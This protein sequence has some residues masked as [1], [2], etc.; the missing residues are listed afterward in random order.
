MNALVPAFIAALLAQAGDRP[1]WLAAILRDRRG[2]PVAILAAIL[3]VQLAGAVIAIAGA[4]VVAPLLVPEARNL[5]L[6][7]ALSFAG[8]GALWPIRPPDRLTGWRIGAFPTAALGLFILTLGDRT[9]FL[10][11][12]IGIASGHPAFAGIGAVAGAF[13][14]NLPAV[15]LGE[16]AWLAL[17][18]DWLRRVSGLLF[19][20]VA[21]P[22][23]LAALRLI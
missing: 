21:V 16:A 12:T 13:L 7:L 6:A 8:I 11:A 5:M 1:P 15:M 9:Q 3:F 23:A 19:L 2:R 20:L 22:L 10:T 4:T 14:A 17:P 18:L